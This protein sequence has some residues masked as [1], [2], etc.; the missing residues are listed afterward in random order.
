MVVDN[1]VSMV[2]DARENSSKKQ[3]ERELN[4]WGL[5]FLL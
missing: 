1:L 5:S 2:D 3:K 4:S